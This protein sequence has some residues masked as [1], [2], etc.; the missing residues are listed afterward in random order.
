MPDAHAPCRSQTGGYAQNETEKILK[1]FFCRIFVHIQS[2]D[3]KRDFF[4][5]LDVH[6]IGGRICIGMDACQ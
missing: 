1:Y 5:C 2:V 4:C 6:F 3:F